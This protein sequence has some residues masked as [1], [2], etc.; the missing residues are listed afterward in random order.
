MLRTLPAAEIAGIRALAVHAKDDAARRQTLISASAVPVDR[1]IHAGLTGSVCWHVGRLRFC[2][3][4]RSMIEVITVLTSATGR[5]GGAGG[6]APHPQTIA[7][8]APTVEALRMMRENSGSGCRHR[9]GHTNR[10]YET[11]A[12]TAHVSPLARI[13]DRWCG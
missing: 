1:A 11:L 10:K 8:A 2:F 3:S 9:Y 5:Y 13:S 7:R 6:A 12:V 4:R